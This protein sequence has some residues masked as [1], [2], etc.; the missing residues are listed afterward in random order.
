MH[1]HQY[2]IDPVLSSIATVAEGS[3]QLTE[4]LGTPR[5]SAT[6]RAVG[7]RRGHHTRLFGGEEVSLVFHEIEAYDRENPEVLSIRR[8]ATRFGI[9]P[10]RLR[11]AIRE[12]D[13]AAFRPGER[14][15][16]VRIGDVRKWLEGHR[17]TPTSSSARRT[18]EAL[19]RRENARGASPGR[20]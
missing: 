14:T 12:G 3:E 9:H 17:V 1:T 15:Q 8:A 2:R 7:Y 11:A 13:L 16:Y 10:R 20:S 6:N 19:L 5:N 4:L 18:A